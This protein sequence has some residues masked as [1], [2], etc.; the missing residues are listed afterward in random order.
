M[1]NPTSFSVDE[2]SADVIIASFFS[3]HSFLLA[4]AAT[5]QDIYE[6]MVRDNSVAMRLS[7]IESMQT[8]HFSFSPNNDEGLDVLTSDISCDLE[9]GDIQSVS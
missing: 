5:M 7:D 6:E 8:S 3:C 9:S 4:R 2:D 1:I